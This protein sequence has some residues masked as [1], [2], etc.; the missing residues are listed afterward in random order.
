MVPVNDA[1]NGEHESIVNVP[2][3]IIG[4]DPIPSVNRLHC[5]KT[6]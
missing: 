1:W 4:N 2:E 5:T 6:E 3:Q